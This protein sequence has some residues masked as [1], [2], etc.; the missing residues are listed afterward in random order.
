MGGVK[1][2]GSAIS[3]NPGKPKQGGFMMAD[4]PQELDDWDSPSP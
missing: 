2:G 3:G 4:D 1:V